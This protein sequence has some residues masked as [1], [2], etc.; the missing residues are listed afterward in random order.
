MQVITNNQWRPLLDW[1]E[2]TTSE[3]AQFD[4]ITDESGT[5]IRYRGACYDLSEFVRCEQMPEWDGIA[6]DTY[7]SATVIKL[8]RDGEYVKVGRAYA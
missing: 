3:Q 2:L 4:Y 6:S 7:F 5:F 8:S 1:H